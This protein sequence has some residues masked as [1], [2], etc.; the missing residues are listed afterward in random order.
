[1]RGQATP[2]HF[3]IKKMKL[4]VPMSAFLRALEVSL[5]TSCQ[6]QG[7]ERLYVKPVARGLLI[8]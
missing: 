8:L 7:K 6:R 3:E 2:P 4:E 5:T 1:L